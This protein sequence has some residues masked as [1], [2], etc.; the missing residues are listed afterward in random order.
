LSE[1]PA[2]KWA[3]VYLTSDPIQKII[4]DLL[5][6]SAAALI[7]F[8]LL[9]PFIPIRV[10]V[11]EVLL[12]AA[13]VVWLL[14][15]R[16][17]AQGLQHR[18]FMIPFIGFLL[19]ATLSGIHAVSRVAVARETIQ[20]G[21]LVAM[22]FFLANAIRDERL[23][24]KLQ[25]L[26]L[27]VSVIASVVGLYQYVLVREPVAGLITTT[28][29][30]AVG[31][32][33]QPNAFGSFLIGVIPM[34]VGSLL[35][36][37]SMNLPVPT[38]K[39]IQLLLGVSVFI[40]TM[41][42]LATFSRGS[43]IGLVVGGSVLLVILWKMIHWHR[44]VAV[45]AVGSVA[46]LIIVFD[47]EQQPSIVDP[48][49]AGRSFSN[50]QRFLLAST[51]IQMAMDYPLFGIGFGNYPKRLPEYASAELKS[52]L[53]RDYD[54]VSKRFFVNPEKEPTIDLVHNM[55]LQVLCETGITGLFFF[56][57]LIGSLL[58]RSIRNV[59]YQESSEALALRAGAFAGL[60]AILVGGIFG[61]PFSHGIQELIIL[62]AG[63][64]LSQSS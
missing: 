50:Q 55:F 58:R 25:I 8:D 6:L 28:R 17:K 64:A 4:F 54:P 63:I 13:F 44:L 57:W 16:G 39:R 1:L 42:L 21:W 9:F 32:Y 5:L 11:A 18:G 35:V 24:V 40:L 60:L 51:A 31:F 14:A 37:P 53:Q 34:A 12:S 30:R 41:C 26:L 20:F 23:V 38:K 52:L 27:I 49:F 48:E 10:S 47:V 19:V 36:L 59:V 3:E 46:A 2:D 56:I 22:I 7:P 15:I 29:F 43:W 62:Q 33:D 61:W 45:T